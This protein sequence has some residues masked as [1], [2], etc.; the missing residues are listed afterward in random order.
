MFQVFETNMQRVNL[1]QSKSVFIPLESFQIVNTQSELAFPFGAKNYGQKKAQELNQRFN[2]YP[3]NSRNRGQ[4]T[5][6]EG[7]NMM[8]EIS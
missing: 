3:Q 6:D 8:L 2:S 1:V 7:C 4:M 5:F